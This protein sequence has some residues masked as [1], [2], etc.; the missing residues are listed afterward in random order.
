MHVIAGLSVS[1]PALKQKL[2]FPPCRRN[3]FYRRREKKWLCHRVTRKHTGKKGLVW[4]KVESFARKVCS[5]IMLR[6]VIVVWCR[7]QTV[8]CIA[9]INWVWWVRHKKERGSWIAG[10][11]WR[12]FFSHHCFP[13]TSLF[14][15][16]FQEELSWFHPLCG[17]DW[18]AMVPWRS[19][20][21]VVKYQ[22]HSAS[23]INECIA[24]T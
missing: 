1:H 7:R 23:V 2:T 10:Q 8:L 16:L 22:Q 5:Q 24:F 21:C 9:V 6:A 12:L 11:S 14:Q 3:L 13:L 20:Q 18:I 4:T 17:H 19:L 15:R